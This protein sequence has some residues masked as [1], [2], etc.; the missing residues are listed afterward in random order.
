VGG[1]FIANL[2]YCAIYS[3]NHPFFEQYKILKTERWPWIEDRQA[4][5]NLM[6]KSLALVIFNG[7]VVFFTITYLLALITNFKLNHSLS[8]E[9]LPDKFT[10]A[11]QVGFL[12]YA[13][14]VGFTCAHRLLHSPFFYRRIHKVHHTYT[15]AVGISATYAHPLE[16]A[17]GNMLPTGIPCLILGKRMHFFTFWVFIL[18]RVTATTNGHSGYEFPWISWDMMPMRGT[19]SYHDYHHSGGD[20]SGN[21][22]G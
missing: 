8:V 5:R 7:T 17:F 1:F 12:I 18:L 3:L 20:F 10:L 22:C 6:L 19:P 15:Q 9:D 11:W 14:D 4:W 21:F 13:E 16:Y 2:V